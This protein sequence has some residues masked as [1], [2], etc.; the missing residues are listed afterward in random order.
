[1]GAA[2]DNTRL[3]WFCTSKVNL[4]KQLFSRHSHPDHETPPSYSWPGQSGKEY[5]FEVYPL[6]ATFQPLP[7]VYI[8]AKELTD[9][10]WSPVYISQ[11]RDLHQRLEGHVTREDAIAN[12][13]THIHAHYCTAGQ[14]A[15]HAEEQDLIHRWQPV[16]NDVFQA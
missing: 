14:G 7:G 12:G 4:I 11:T 9:G 13:A 15:R 10:D 6:D 1:M 8:Y 5:P 2:V 3:R 16:C